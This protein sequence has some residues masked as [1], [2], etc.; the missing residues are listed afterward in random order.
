MKDIFDLFKAQQHKLEEMPSAAAWQKLE[1]RLDDH[2]KKPVRLLI[3]RRWAIAASILVMLS[4]ASLFSTRLMPSKARFANFEPLIIESVSSYD[5]ITLQRKYALGSIEEGK[6]SKKLLAAMNYFYNE[7]PEKTL[8]EDT[9]KRQE[10]KSI[11]PTPIDFDWLLGEWRG[12]TSAG[13]SI[14]KWEQSNPNTFL[15]EGYLV[16]GKDTIL[17][18]RMKLLRQGDSW[19]YALQLD[20]HFEAA[21]YRL[22][23]ASQNQMVFRSKENIFP[24]QVILQRNNEESFSTI[25]LSSG[26]IELSTSRLDFLM[27]RNVLFSNR[28]IR[29]L[30]RERSI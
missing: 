16:K 26:T 20:R 17:V 29:N 27:Q 28:A 9:I 25:L 2:K 22:E 14:E 5:V 13:A 10:K 18:E 4:F 7:L 30:Y 6:A 21:T 23:T 1:K 3:A 24:K 8:V 15:G 19:Y 11:A 12:N